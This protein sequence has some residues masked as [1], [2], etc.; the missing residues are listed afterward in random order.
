MVKTEFV[1]AIVS[2]E[3]YPDILEE[4]EKEAFSDLLDAGCG[5]APNPQ[6]FFD[7]VKRCLRPG[8]R[9]ERTI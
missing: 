8:G 1:G 2:V 6:A 7:S 4:L 5:P 9:H 3:D